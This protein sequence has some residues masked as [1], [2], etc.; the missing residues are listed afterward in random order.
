MKML[1]SRFLSGA[2]RLTISR[3]VMFAMLLGPIIGSMIA[4][5]AVAAQDPTSVITIDN[6]TFAPKELNVAV[7][8]TIKWVNHDDIPH[9]VVGK[10]KAFR[11]PPA[12]DTDESYSFT[13]TTAGTFDYSCGLHPQMVGKV[14]VKP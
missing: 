2:G 3:A 10:D 4:L 11:S 8:T 13:F 6:F 14:V 9:S 5:V 12:L 7:G 1:I